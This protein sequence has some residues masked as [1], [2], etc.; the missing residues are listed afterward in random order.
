MSCRCRDFCC[1]KRVFSWLHVS[2]QVFRMAEKSVFY[3]EICFNFQ[4]LMWWALAATAPAA[5]CS[6]P[7]PDLNKSPRRSSP[8]SLKQ[9]RILGCCC[10]QRDN[11]DSASVWSW[12]EENC[13]CC[14]D[15][16]EPDNTNLLLHLDILGNQSSTH[17]GLLWVSFILKMRGN[18]MC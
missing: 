10:M 3:L 2:A 4:P 11:M 6:G 7:V 15:K 13:F 18:L 8:W 9:W 12:T 14:L 5:W 17:G 1:C 16:V